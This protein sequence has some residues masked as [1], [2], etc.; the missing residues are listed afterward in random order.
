MKEVILL[1][2]VMLMS[3]R[4]DTYYAI[5]ME[6]DI[7]WYN[8]VFGKEKRP[9][10]KNQ[11]YTIRQI[12]N[13]SFSAPSFSGTTMTEASDYIDSYGLLKYDKRRRNNGWAN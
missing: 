13:R 11:L 10:T 8:T 3:S 1:V 7:R 6:E 5:R 4:T 12:Q 2:G 9:P